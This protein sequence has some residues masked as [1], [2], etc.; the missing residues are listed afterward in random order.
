[1]FKK[2]NVVQVTDFERW[3]DDNY[4][5]LSEI[6]GIWHPVIQA[7][8]SEINANYDPHDAMANGFNWKTG[9]ARQVD[10]QVAYDTGADITDGAT[11][12]E[13]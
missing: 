2:L 3:A 5:P 7:R 10:N 1:M 4:V 12:D 8:C 13:K 9:Y 11:D 6:K